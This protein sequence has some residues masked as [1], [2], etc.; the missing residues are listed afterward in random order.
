MYFKR[1]SETYR[2][3][4]ET[5]TTFDYSKRTGGKIYYLVHESNVTLANFLIPESN[6]LSFFRILPNI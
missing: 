6:I 3:I 5:C 1:I 4:K 2:T